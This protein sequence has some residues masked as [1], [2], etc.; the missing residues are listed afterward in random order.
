MIVDKRIY[1]LKPGGVPIYMKI[2]EEF[3]LKPQTRHLGQPLG[4][5]FSEVGTLNQ[6]THLWGYEDL[7]DRTAK[8]AAMGADPDWQVY[9]KK[10]GEAGI[11]LKQENQILVAAPWSP[12]PRGK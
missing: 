2:Y 6:I 7:A 1:S 8:R 12:D 5:Y 10:M 11:L 3:G 4:W 9:I